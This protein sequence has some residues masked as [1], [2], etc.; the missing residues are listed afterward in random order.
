[1]NIMRTYVRMYVQIYSKNI[2]HISENIA[3]IKFGDLPEIWPN[4]LLAEFKFGGL[5][6]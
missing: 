6:E 4:A 3:V 5:P 1:M 2:Y